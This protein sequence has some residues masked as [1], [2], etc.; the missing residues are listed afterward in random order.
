MSGTVGRQIPVT[1][2]LETQA[3]T[4]STTLTGIVAAV[5]LSLVA[6]EAQAQ[7]RI[8]MI[9]AAQPAVQPFIQPIQPPPVVLPKFGFQSFNVHGV[10]EQVT[11]VNCH[12]LAEQ[13]GLERGDMILSLN[14]RSLTYHGAWNQALT[15]VMLQG[16]GMI[17]L[18]IRDIR[19]GQVVHRD[20][21]VGG[22]GIGPITPKS[23]P[24]GTPGPIQNRSIQNGPVQNNSVQG[25]A[26]NSNAR[27]S[28]ATQLGN[29]FGQLLRA[30]Q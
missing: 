24:V 15:N 10:G 13:L 9:G 2:F 8:Q 17:H 25:N 14:G 23:M 26:S 6:T 21:F 3:M 12:S 5:A 30:A 4:R 18:N 11:F 27:R 29:Q 28:V 1:T 16:G 19:T 7:Q 20:A 22:T